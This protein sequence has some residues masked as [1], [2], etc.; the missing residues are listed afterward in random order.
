[1]KAWTAGLEELK[2]G[3]DGAEAGLPVDAISLERTVC[4]KG[5]GGSCP[6]PRVPRA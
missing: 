6:P 3:K 1:M 4:G 5:Q 2:A